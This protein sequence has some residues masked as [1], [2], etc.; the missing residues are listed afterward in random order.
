MDHIQGFVDE[1]KSMPVAIH[2]DSANEQH[3]EVSAVVASTS[4][5]PRSES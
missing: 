5:A 3:Y 2:T 4:F 1:L